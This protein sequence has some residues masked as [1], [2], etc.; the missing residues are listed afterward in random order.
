MEVGMR[1]AMVAM[2][3]M[4]SVACGAGSNPDGGG[5]CKTTVCPCTY[6]FS[7]AATGTTTC[8]ASFTKDNSTNQT[9]VSILAERP[10][11]STTSSNFSST[12][13]TADLATTTYT[14]G[15]VVSASTV[16]AVDIPEGGG[17]KNIWNQYAHDPLGGDQGTFS[18]TISSIGTKLSGGTGSLWA[19]PHGMLD[20]TLTPSQFSTTA[21]GTVAVH[22]SF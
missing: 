6:T 12:L 14:P 20:V 18:L 15:N 19:N 3:A 5:A 8:L 21:T 11:G 13:G 4:V 7:G 17:L 9:T 10:S 2:G 1:A 22:V 16:V